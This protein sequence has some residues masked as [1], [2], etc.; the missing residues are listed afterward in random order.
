MPRVLIVDDNLLIR[1][2]L[3]QIFRDGGYVVV[4]EA[5]DGVEAV[6]RVSEMRPDLV[7]LDLVMPRCDGFETLERLRIIDPSLPVIVC[8][9]RLTEHNVTRA[10]RLGA[11]DFIAKPFD[12]DTVLDRARRVLADASRGTVA[13]PGAPTPPGRFV[14]RPVSEDRR[15]FARVIAS[16]PVVL[17]SESGGEIETITIDISGG[18]MLLGTRAIEPGATVGFRL[19]LAAEQPPVTGMARAVGVRE[20]AQQAF[21]F[22]QVSIADHERLIQYLTAHQPLTPPAGI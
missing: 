20:E 11:T 18:G 19:E 17:I 14:R 9:A 21:A 6:S 2:L 8:S 13:Q 10:L 12:S 5:Q 1:T 4:G 3:R 22:E 16:L 7:M 15:E